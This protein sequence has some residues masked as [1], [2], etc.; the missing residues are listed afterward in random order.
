MVSFN[1]DP[2]P[3]GSYIIKLDFSSEKNIIYK[4]A[5]I[6]RYSVQALGT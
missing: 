4:K 6:Y 5:N 2:N 1:T 3:V